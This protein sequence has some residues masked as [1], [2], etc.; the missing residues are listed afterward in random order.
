M[1]EHE[2]AILAFLLAFREGSTCDSVNYRWFAERYPHFLY[3]DRVLVSDA[4]QGTGLGS[5]LY[6]TVFAHAQASS[7]PLV[8]CEF[9][10]DPPNPASAS[11]HARFG[12]REVGQQQVAFGKKT[13]SLQAAAV[14]IQYPAHF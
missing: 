10:I 14:K 12:F 3:V 7:V 11:F 13:V 5:L 9:D 8:T 4:A 1:I 2:A 6:R